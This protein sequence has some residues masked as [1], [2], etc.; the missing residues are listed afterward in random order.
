[1]T[2][3]TTLLAAATVAVTVAGCGYPETKMEPVGQ[4]QIQ[5]QEQQPPAQPNGEQQANKEKK[6][7]G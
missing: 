6:N 7:A 3:F 4:T 2:R 5:T 1:M